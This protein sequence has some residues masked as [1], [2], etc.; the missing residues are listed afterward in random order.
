MVFVAGTSRP[1]FCREP[2]CSDPGLL[3]IV[4]DVEV[5]ERRRAV[6]QRPPIRHG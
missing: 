6:G 1:A 5:V 2:R 3:L 4:D